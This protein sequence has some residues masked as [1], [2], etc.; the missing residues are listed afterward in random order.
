MAEEEFNTSETPAAKDEPVGK[1]FHELV[2][3]ADLHS[4]AP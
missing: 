1:G 2:N 4:Y 3:S